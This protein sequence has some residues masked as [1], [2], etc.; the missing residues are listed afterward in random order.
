MSEHNPLIQANNRIYDLEQENKHLKSRIFSLENQVNIY[1]VYKNTKYDDSVYVLY[2]ELAYEL[3][4]N[5]GFDGYICHPVTTD[6]DVTDFLE[7]D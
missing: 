2:E 5:G 1:E 6:E 4:E 3:K 7:H